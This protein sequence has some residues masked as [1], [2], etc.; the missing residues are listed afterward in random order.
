MWSAG[1]VRFPRRSRRPIA[2]VTDTGS[3]RR[4][5]R[6]SRASNRARCGPRPS[7][8]SPNAARNAR[9]AANAVIDPPRLSDCGANRRSPVTAFDAAT[10]DRRKDRRPAKASVNKGVVQYSQFQR[11]D[12]RPLRAAATAFAVV[13]GGNGT[14]DVTSAQD[15]GARYIRHRERSLQDPM[16]EKQSDAFGCDVFPRTPVAAIDAERRYP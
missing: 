9:T 4:S 8:R 12:G 11:R 1:R 13:D 2:I 14:N 5:G 7:E 15:L 10:D 3:H 6:W 16:N